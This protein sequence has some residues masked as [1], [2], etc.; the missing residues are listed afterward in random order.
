MRSP[1]RA[2][3]R[4]LRLQKLFTASADQY[5]FSARPGKGQGKR[6]AYPL[7]CSS[8]DCQPAIETE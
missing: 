2:F 8:H 1:A 4:A 3:Y 5:D 7:A 6:P